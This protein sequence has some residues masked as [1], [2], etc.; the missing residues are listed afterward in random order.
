VYDSWT[1]EDGL[2]E[3]CGDVRNGMEDS[4]SRAG[5]D[6]VL[7]RPDASE[8]FPGG[9][10][11]WAATDPSPLSGACWRVQCDEALEVEFVTP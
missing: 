5:S 7:L 8:E 4:A 6:A 11:R 10:G 3:V 2:V 1:G 9:G